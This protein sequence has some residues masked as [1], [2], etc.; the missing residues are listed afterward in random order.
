MISSRTLEFG[1][2]LKSD[3]LMIPRGYAMAAT[4]PDGCTRLTWH[5]K[6]ACVGTNA[7]HLPSLAE[8]LNEKGQ[9]TWLRRRTLVRW[10]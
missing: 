7:F 10:L 5:T 9:A 8:G 6:Y 1:V 2:D 3:V 4:M